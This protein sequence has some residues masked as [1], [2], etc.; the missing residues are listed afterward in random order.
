MATA[1]IMSAPAVV[2]NSAS[3]SASTV[4][5]I[6][7]M[8]ITRAGDSP[9]IAPRKPPASAMTR[10]A[11]KFPN[12]TRPTPWEEWGAKAPEKMKLPKAT[13]ATSSPRPEV[14]P[15]DNAGTV[16][17]YRMSARSSDA[18]SRSEDVT[19]MTY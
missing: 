19:R 7:A 12:S 17:A 18:S 13:W 8:T 11:A 9:A 14:N 2:T 3:P 16:F 5:P 6:R 4:E 15:A 10:Q 1:P